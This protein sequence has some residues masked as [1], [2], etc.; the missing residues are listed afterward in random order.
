MVWKT[1]LDP[2]LQVSE[3]SKGEAALGDVLGWSLW[4]GREQNDVCPQR[5]ANI[6]AK[7]PALIPLATT[8]NTTSLSPVSVSSSPLS[9]VL[10]SPRPTEPFGLESLLAKAQSQTEAKSTSDDG[11]VPYRRLLLAPLAGPLAAPSN[12]YSVAKLLASSGSAPSQAPHLSLLG[13]RPSVRPLSTSD[14]SSSFASATSY[15][16]SSRSPSTTSSDDESCGGDDESLSTAS[17]SIETAS[18]SEHLSAIDEGETGVVGLV[19]GRQA[20]RAVAES[21]R[22]FSDVSGVLTPRAQPMSKKLRVGD[23]AGGEDGA[24]FARSWLAR[25]RFEGEDAMMGT[26]VNTVVG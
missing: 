24:S 1:H 7:A 15:A 9:S 25:E 23:G 8:P 16:A 26:R 4:V 10:E 12:F 3:V 5:E 13:H 11:E 22:R 19:L 17:S 14:S 6:A 18:D 21:K 20:S 2:S